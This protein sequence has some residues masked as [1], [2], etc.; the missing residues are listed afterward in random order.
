METEKQKMLNGKWFHSRDPELI[1]DKN[2]IITFL[3]VFN[4]NENPYKVEEKLRDV[5]GG[6]G[7][8]VKVGRDFDVTYGYNLFIGDDVSIN[9]GCKFLDTGKIKIGNLCF[10]G[11]NVHFYATSHPIDPKVR[12]NPETHDLVLPG[13]IVIGEN[14]W[15]GGNVTIIS[16][17]H[18]G[19][20]SVIGAGSV[21]T[22]DIPSNTVAVGNPARVIKKLQ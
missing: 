19:D 12:R 11:P 18:I 10:I 5:L 6:I 2:K 20:N 9:R 13:E 7:T 4:Q 3:K 1:K 17:V 8:N 14:V 15:I 16:G 21:V 22:K